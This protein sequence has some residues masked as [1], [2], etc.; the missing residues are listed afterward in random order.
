MKARQTNVPAVDFLTTADRPTT[1]FARS[2]SPGLFPDERGSHPDLADEASSASPY[3]RRVNDIG[4]ELRR[5]VE[6]G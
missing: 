4:Q 1:L 6:F 5:Y 3:G 2:G